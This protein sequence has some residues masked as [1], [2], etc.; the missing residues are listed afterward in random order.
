MIESQ[1]SLARSTQV[2][3][4]LVLVTAAGMGGVTMR[5]LF[6]DMFVYMW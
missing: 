4:Q 1:Y 2:T 6:V 5:T 3:L